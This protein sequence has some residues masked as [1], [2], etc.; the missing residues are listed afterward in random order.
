MGR[1]AGTDGNGATVF[2]TGTPLRKNSLPRRGVGG[3]AWAL[4][5]TFETALPR[6]GVDA[7]FGTA[8]CLAGTALARREVGFPAFGPIGGVSDAAHGAT[9]RLQRL[10]RPGRGMGT[11]PPAG[12]GAAPY[13]GRRALGQCANLRRGQGAAPCAARRVLVK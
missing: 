9:V 2:G 3:G 13:A 1:G 10:M 11:P 5:P 4:R 8:D 7:V 12:Q 6:R